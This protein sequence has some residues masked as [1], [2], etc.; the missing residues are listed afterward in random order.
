MVMPF[1][2]NDVFSLSREWGYAGNPA[3][4][5]LTQLFL[6]LARSKRAVFRPGL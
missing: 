2:H 5:L 3:E 6:L 4:A 1:L